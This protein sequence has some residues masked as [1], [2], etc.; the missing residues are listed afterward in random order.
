MTSRRFTLSAVLIVLAFSCSNS[1]S[2]NA[3][4]VM[5]QCGREISALCDE[6][7]SG[8]GRI[9]ACLYAR[10]DKLSPGC[11]EEVDRVVQ[12]TA[13]SV[14]STEIRENNEQSESLR[15]ICASDIERYCAMVENREGRTLACLYSRQNAVSSDCSGAM[16]DLL[17]L[18]F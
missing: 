6:V 16:D 18:L 13:L 15:L 2:A 11:R 9:T 5:G 10:E 7:V 4:D 8:K 12:H 3:A 14:S 1:I 17:S